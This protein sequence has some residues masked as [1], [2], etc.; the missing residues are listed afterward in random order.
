MS[1]CSLCD[2]S[3]SAPSFYN[4]GL[5]YSQSNNRVVFTKE[6]GDICTSCLDSLN[7]TRD[8]YDDPERDFEDVAQ[9]TDDE[10]DLQEITVLDEADP[11]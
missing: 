6:H 9:L 10:T 4:E 11:S 1:R 8:G 5:R 2:Y 3:Q 7:A